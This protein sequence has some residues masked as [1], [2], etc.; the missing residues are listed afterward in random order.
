VVIGANYRALGVVRSLGRHGIPVWVLRQEDELLATLS[1][2]TLHHLAWPTG[3]ESQ[4]IDFLTELGAKYGLQGWVLLPTGDENT[5]LVARHHEGLGKQ[6]QLSTLPWNVLCWVHDKRLLYR[7][8]QC[9]AIDCPWTFYPNTCADLAALDCPF[10]VI[11]KPAMKTGFNRFIA[12]KAWQVNDRQALLARYYEACRLVAPDLIMVQEVVPGGGETQFS[13]AALFQDGRPLASLVARR[14]RQFPMNFGRASTFVETVDE[15]GVVEP[16]VRLLA[17][18]RFTGLVEVE[19]KHDRRDGRYKLLDVNP[20]IWGW[21]SL[22]ERAGVD[23]PY[24]LWQ[25]IR[26]DTVPEVRGAIGVKWMRMSTDL[27]IA[28]QE[29]LR[30]RLSFCT[31]IRSFRAPHKSAIFAPD[32]PLPGLLELPL[33][34]YVIGRRWFRGSGI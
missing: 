18:L 28:M 20:R 29:I 4:G 8:A 21:I 33:L 16:A 5:A 17:T 9:L 15:P 32:D 25:L 10:P 3:D 19:F 34:A 6:F 13:Y 2:Y 23:F 7:L 27:P 22:C 30:G 11:L 1:R 12:A 26:G 31:Y 24:L 14:T